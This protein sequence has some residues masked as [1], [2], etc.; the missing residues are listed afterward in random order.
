MRGHRRPAPQ[1]DGELWLVKTAYA[2][3]RPKHECS[4]RGSIRVVLP[5]LWAPRASSSSAPPPVLPHDTLGDP[6][7]CSL[8]ELRR[9][10][11][12]GK[13]SATSGPTQPMRLPR[14]W[15]TLTNV[16]AVGHS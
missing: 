12:T 2:L 13:P 8:A 11:G 4:L 16:S 5:R 14:P 9:L 3:H 10:R 15:M 6:K 1:S 7:E